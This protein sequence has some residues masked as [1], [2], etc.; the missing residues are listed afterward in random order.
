LT[1][2]ASKLFVA[3]A[4]TADGQ[5]LP[6][7]DVTHPNFALADDPAAI[8]AVSKSYAESE[9]QRARVPGFVMR[10]ML[11]RAARRSLLVRAIVY[12]DA[13]FLSGL[14]T[15]VMKLGAENLP[16][17]FNTD[18]DRRLAAA[19]QL[20]SMRLRLQQTA[21]LL[22]EGLEPSLGAAPSAPLHLIN[23]GGG[24]AVDTLNALILLRKSRTEVLARQIVI[25]VLDIDSAGPRFGANALEA[26]RAEGG[27]LAGLDVTFSHESY[28]WN[29]S[30]LL[31]GLVRQASS[32]GA[33]IAA[34]S[35]GALFEYGNDDAIVANLQS[36][37]AGGTGATLV[38]GSVTR[39]DTPRQVATRRF[40]L[41]PRGVDGFAPLAKRAGFN[42]ARV[43]ETPLSDQVL[44]RP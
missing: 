28:D 15:Y 27:T 42:V 24:P 40:K 21:K 6:V 1:S 10:L 35:E 26:L 14:N 4:T 43:E 39:V 34:S 44:L 5:E 41:V 16:P 23:I 3:H 20:T 32:Q 18:V 8:A 7:I 38:V 25:H 11:R 36:L 29:D 22:A 2:P 13:S 30:A 17:P 9:R 19:P 12:A 33:I 31:D 37:H